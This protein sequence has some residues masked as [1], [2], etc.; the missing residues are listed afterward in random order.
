[1]RLPPCV[2]RRERDLP[3]SATSARGVRF[4]DGT[5]PYAPHATLIR[6]RG[7]KLY[8]GVENGSTGR[9]S[10]S[11][12]RN[13]MSED[14]RRRATDEAAPFSRA[15]RPRQGQDAWGPQG[16]FWATLS[17]CARECRYRLC[18]VE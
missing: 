8:L 6:Q 3:L 18:D 2:C 1:M 4:T 5:L 17:S 13:P 7:W 15:A 14:L 12:R 16:M 11:L 9:L 10:N